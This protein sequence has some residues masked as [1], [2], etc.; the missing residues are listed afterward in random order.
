M[1]VLVIHGPNLN[2]L[3]EREPSVYGTASLPEI[4]AAIMHGARELHVE[5][6]VV[7]HNGEGDIIDSI[8]EARNEY[9]AVIINPGAYSHYSYAIA[10]AVASVSIPVIEV[11][12]SNIYARE[13]FRRTSVIAPACAGSIVGFGSQSY[14]LALRAAVA[15]TSPVERKA[16]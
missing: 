11:H 3:G 12:L 16:P 13:A 10:D 4:D 8:H 15:L 6:H 9:D 2:L 7:Q 14:I 5:A 1:R